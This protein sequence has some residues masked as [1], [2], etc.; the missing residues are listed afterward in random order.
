[1]AKRHLKVVEQVSLLKKR[2]ML[3]VDEIE[4]AKTLEKFGYYRLSGYW[5]QFRIRIEEEGTVKTLEEFIPGTSF[6]QI[7]DIYRFDSDLRHLVF[8]EI[9]Q[10]EIA[11]RFQIGHILG[12]LNV[13][14]HNDETLFKPTFLASVEERNRSQHAAL[15]RSIQRELDRSNEDFVSHHLENY[16]GEL[17]IW[18]VTEVMGFQ[19]L[20]ML[21][22]GLGDKYQNAI[23]ANFGLRTNAGDGLGGELMNWME[24]ILQVR[25]LCAHHSRLWNRQ[26]SKNLKMNH[27]RHL[28]ETRHIFLDFRDATSKGSKNADVATKRLYASLVV[29][30]TLNKKLDLDSTWT[31]KLKDLLLTL[32]EPGSLFQMGFPA[33]WQE[34]EIWGN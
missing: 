2:G 7:E 18:A 32:P 4:C 13:Y 1:M 21:Y 27:L 6:S 10:I 3:I 19:H 5:Y 20:F 24:I 16:G 34:L 23:A 9:E 33:N 29:L 17:P 28:D 15:I 30:L 22:Q 12:E 14:A 11:L 31:G 26:F 8:H 25:N